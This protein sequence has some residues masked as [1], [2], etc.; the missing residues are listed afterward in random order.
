MEALRACAQSQTDVCCAT[1]TTA[2]SCVLARG[3]VCERLM[4][5][6]SLQKHQKIT[7]HRRILNVVIR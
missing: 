4:L 5:T 7:K 6:V 2:E 3:N 1:A